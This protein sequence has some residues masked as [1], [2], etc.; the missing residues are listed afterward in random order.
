MAVPPSDDQEVVTKVTEVGQSSDQGT[1][2]PSGGVEI[3]SQ[4]QLDPE[5]GANR[6][7][8]SRAYRPSLKS[9]QTQ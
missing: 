2:D 3:G 5:G 4:L 8:F 1:P 6:L 9:L 7:E